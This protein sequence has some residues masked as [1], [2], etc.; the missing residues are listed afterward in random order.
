MMKK[1]L[2]IILISFMW[3]F[4]GN[5][6][7]STQIREGLQYDILDV[8]DKAK[9]MIKANF[10]NK[11]LL[12]ENDNLYYIHFKLLNYENINDLI[13]K[14]DNYLIGNITYLSENKTDKTYVL[15]IKKENINKAINVFGYVIPMQMNIK[16]SI[17]FNLNNLNSVSKNVNIEEY[18]PE[19]IPEI[20]FIDEKKNYISQVNNEFLIPKASA[21]IG[22]KSLDLDVK[23][24][25]SDNNSLSINN[26]KVKFIK[27]GLHLITYE[28]SSS[29]YKTSNNSDAKTIATIKVNV[30]S[31]D[32]YYKLSDQKTK[33][34]ILSTDSIFTTLKLTVKD[35][36]EDKK[37]RVLKVFSKHQKFYFYQ[38]TLKKNNT[39]FNN[40]E[41][42]E[43][44]FPQKSN[45]RLDN[46]NVYY[47]NGNKFEKVNYKYNDNFLNIKTNK[48]GYYL[49]IDETKKA[50]KYILILYIFLGIISFIGL[51]IGFYY[52][53]RKKRNK[54]TFKRS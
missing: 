35:I 49:I 11:F 46:T 36:S 32:G 19:F 8:D 28:A 2:L 37:D 15:T 22:E 53:Y 33:I 27:S 34:E 20:T 24:Y 31:E 17:K 3:L 39:D 12:E 42:L 47:Y 14:M 23:L 40:L 38:I 18:A 13:F 26:N 50:N 1:V 44:N 10:S 29:L 41:N 30:V 48:V 4:F 54:F 6:L 21:K 5:S 45:F 43:I 25:D 52:I 51:F 16:F 9:E 7:K